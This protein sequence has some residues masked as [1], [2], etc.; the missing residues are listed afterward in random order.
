MKNTVLRNI[1]MR[2]LFTALLLMLAMQGA[3]AIDLQDAKSQG[4]VGDANTGYLEAVGSSPS[5]EVRALI[6]DVNSKR[7]A[8]F[9][10]TAAKTGATLEQVR[11]RFYQL[12]V[13]KTATGHYY[14][15]AGG[16][17]KKK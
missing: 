8:E 16:S 10:S 14:Q 1:S 6:A 11:A 9:E 3:W 2:Q 15:D 7:K 5:S 12:A 17:W 13:Q 4:L